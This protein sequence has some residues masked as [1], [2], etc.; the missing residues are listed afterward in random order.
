[1]PERT[2]YDS[3]LRVLWQVVEI[4]VFVVLVI[5]DRKVPSWNGG[6]ELAVRAPT[7][8]GSSASAVTDARELALKP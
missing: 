8:P 1:M 5:K 7:R 3:I 4:Y 2:V 6:N